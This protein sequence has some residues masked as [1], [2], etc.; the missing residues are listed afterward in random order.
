MII[1]LAVRSLTV[2]K[3]KQYRASDGDKQAVQIETVDTAF[4]EHLHEQAT[5]ECTEDAYDYVC[6]GSLTRVS[7]GDE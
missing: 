2:D 4:A 7:S 5:D 1:L 3:E 6:D